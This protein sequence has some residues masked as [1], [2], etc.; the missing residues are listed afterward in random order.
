LKILFIMRHSGFVRNFESTLRM[1]CERGHRVHVAFLNDDRH[2]L[3]DTTNIAQQL[4]GE[5]PLF[6]RGTAP[7]RDDAWG[8]LGRELRGTLDYLR[9]LTPLYRNAPKLRARAAKDVSAAVLQMTQRGPFASRPGL[10]VLAA[11]YRLLEGSIPVG[12]EIDAFVAEQ[13]PDLLL[14]S[15]LIEPGS[16]QREYVRAARARRIRTVLCVGSWD[17]LTNKGLIHGR[18]DLVT[19]WND[20]MRKEAVELHGVRADR[21]AVTGAQQFDHWFTWQPSTSREAFCARVGLDATQP[22]LLYLCS[23]K[24]VAPD[25]T[26]FVRQ[27]IRELRESSSPR[28]RSV[29]VLVRPHPQNEEQWSQFD[30]SDLAHC[31]IY[32]KA[33]AI[34]IDTASKADYFDSIYHSAAVVGINTTAEIESAIVGRQVYTLLAAEFNETQVGTVHFHYLREAGGGLVHVARDF[35]EHLLQLDAALQASVEGDPRCR[36]FVEAFI[37]PQG[38]DVASTPKL[39][40]AI[41]TAATRPAIDGRPSWLAARMLQ[42]LLRRRAARA[43]RDAALK[44]E[45]KAA[46]RKV[47]SELAKQQKKR[48]KKEQK[49]GRA[50]AGE[51]A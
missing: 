45:A 17:N 13:Q 43:E 44:L 4:C 50:E 11:W 16:P 39:V 23:S 33:G 6:S 25:E 37:R 5:Y 8:V 7:V 3:V 29:G 15:P 19:V 28:L 38:I 31:A 48:Q 14:I 27:W 9:Y 30:A 32:P 24:F 46:E 47:K 51:P 1:L 2:W 22:Y 34:P 40:D 42:P 35:R 41:E 12:D 10:A 18:F 26:R 36:R 49:R 20:H 21:V